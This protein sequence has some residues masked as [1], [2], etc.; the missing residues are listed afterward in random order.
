MKLAKIGSRAATAALIVAMCWT[1]ACGDDS[2]ASES[3]GSGGAT[4]TATTTTSTAASTG[5]GGSGGSGSMCA[6]TVNH[7]A[8]AADTRNKI[9]S[10]LPFATAPRR[11]VL[12]NSFGQLG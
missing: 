8:E 7:P 4:S 11:F 6:D 1:V 10:P 2:G 9:D 12:D 5:A 3:G